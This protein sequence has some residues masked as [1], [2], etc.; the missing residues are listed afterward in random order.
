MGLGGRRY[1]PAALPL[2]KTR[3]PLYRMLGGP[4]GKSGQVRKI[5]FPP[6]F[7]LRTVQ[8][9]ASRYIE[10]LYIFL[11]VHVVTNSWK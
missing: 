2:R 5:S 9:V 4:Q 11:T 6:G 3:Y 10:I 7:D 1:A 8:P